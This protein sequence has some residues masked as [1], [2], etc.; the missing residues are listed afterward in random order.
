MIRKILCCLFLLYPLLGWAQNEMQTI[1]AIKSDINFLYAT[2]TSTVSADEAT[3]VARELIELEIEQWLKERSVT[4][5]A[6]YIAKSKDSLFQIDTRRGN[7]YRAFVFVKKQNI[8]PYNSNETVLVK[9]FQQTQ[10]QPEVVATTPTTPSAQTFTPNARERSLLAVTTFS[11]LNDYINQ[12]RQS[13]LI[14]RVG[15]YKTLPA[16]EACY[17]FIHNREGDIPAHIKWQGAKAVNMATGQSDSIQ[18][19]KGCGAIWIQFNDK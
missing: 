5:A 9:D 14:A 15:N 12:G 16:T 18:N 6:G 19:Y 3:G 2:G 10:T 17:V 13:G 7:L 1:N 8:I 11:A 4:D